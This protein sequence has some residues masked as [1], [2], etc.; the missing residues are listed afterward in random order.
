MA[1]VDDADVPTNE[2]PR[3][4]QVSEIVA[5]ME[6]EILRKRTDSVCS[7]SERPSTASAMRFSPTAL[8]APPSPAPPA[9]KPAPATLAPP[10]M[11][12]HAKPAGAP[13]SPL[14]SNP[15]FV[16]VNGKW[17]ETP[18]T[19]AF[20]QSA[21]MKGD[22][23]VV[24]V[25]DLMKRTEMPA[26][27]LMPAQPA[28]VTVSIP[29]S[30]SP[31]S[32]QPRRR[33]GVS[34]AVAAV[35]M[36]LECLG[37]SS[38][39]LLSAQ[40]AGTRSDAGLHEGEAGSSGELPM[41][42]VVKYAGASLL[43]T[44]TG[45][46][47][48]KSHAEIS[49]RN[50][51]APALNVSKSQV[52]IS[53]RTAEITPRAAQAPRSP[54][55]KK[56]VDDVDLL[57]ELDAAIVISGSKESL[58]SSVKQSKGSLRQGNERSNNG[59]G[60]LSNVGGAA[61]APFAGGLATPR[62]EI[63]PS[64]TSALSSL[65][66]N[67]DQPSN[68]SRAKDSQS[69]SSLS[70]SKQNSQSS[71]NRTRGPAPPLGN[72]KAS[73]TRED[74]E[75]T[76]SS[77]VTRFS[78]ILSGASFT[79]P[80]EQASSNLAASP[81][82]SDAEEDDDD[83]TPTKAVA[84]SPRKN[85]SMPQPQ[86]Q[87]QQS[88]TDPATPQSVKRRVKKRSAIA[89]SSKEVSKTLRENGQAMGKEIVGLEDGL[90]EDNVNLDVISADAFKQGKDKGPMAKSPVGEK[91]IERKGIGRGGGKELEKATLDTAG[92]IKAVSYRF[93]FADGQLHCFS[94]KDG[95]V[96]GAYPLEIDQILAA[97]VEKER[98][99][100]VTTSRSTA[101]STT[102]IDF[103]DAKIADQW[104]KVINTIACKGQPTS[105]TTK[106]ALIFLDDSDIR[107]ARD[108]FKHQLLP[109]LQASGKG[110]EVT[111]VA[112]EPAQLEQALKAVDKG[113]VN[114]VAFVSTRARSKFV[115]ER[116]T[117]FI[118]KNGEPL[119]E[120]KICVCNA[121]ISKS[122]KRGISMLFNNLKKR[123]TMAPLK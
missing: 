24:D 42:G 9:A 121:F 100:L 75:V 8:D 45:T 112:F 102:E 119:R 36:K 57:A 73:L 77:K 111:P 50:V 107:Q 60:S 58:A 46:A 12:H 90:E 19:S 6:F 92:K 95:H 40:D 99:T 120:P 66:K 32:D 10:A 63:D 23:G 1:D 38:E 48:S 33:S 82:G 18:A 31:G 34:P 21:L 68:S 5:R 64:L 30:P 29:G 109:I 81:E 14:T 89:W 51:E 87:Q 101:V 103:P 55:R 37:K 20:F 118:F 43:A 35:L 83:R 16:K 39:A 67:L 53:A 71:L 122:E 28:M 56:T 85:H 78:T 105:I 116:L 80:V 2:R 52:E 7:N 113:R 123:T 84:I 25:D 96:Y 97:T 59:S 11:G 70:R 76:N 114:A 27:L 62:Q 13:P 47:F 104:G 49:T 17:M 72:S 61:R 98:V 65:A 41:P 91:I 94:E 15:S 88:S 93:R 54:Q 22:E 3:K 86:T 110:F 79:E 106:Q 117:D 69:I 115:D 108:V 74:S 26:P 44:S 4:S